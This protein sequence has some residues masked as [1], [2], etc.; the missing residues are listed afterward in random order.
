MDHMAASQH[1]PRRTNYMFKAV[2]TTGWIDCNTNTILD[3]HYSMKQLHDTNVAWQIVKRNIERLTVVIADKG[4]D[5]EL[6]R[7]N[8]G[9]RMSN[10]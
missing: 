6:H 1:Y 4:Y 3:I 7:H 2:K 5:W 10:P 8:F 9:L